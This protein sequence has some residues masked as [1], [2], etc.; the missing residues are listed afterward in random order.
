MVE[1]VE[2]LGPETKSHGLG[3]AKV[4][5][6]PD[7][8]L[9]SAETAQ[10]IAPETTL[11]PDGRCSKSRAIEDLAARISRPIELQWHSWINVRAGIEGDA[12]GT[13]NGAHEAN[14]RSRSGQ[15]E[16]VQRPAAPESVDHLMR[17]WRGQIVGHTGGESMPD[18]K[19][20]MPTVCIRAKSEAGV[21]RNVANASVEALSIEWDKV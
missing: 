2:E 16:P 17:P 13:E 5:L 6:H 21:L 7:I 20:R 11:L 9:G 10:H 14:G 19:I 18:V 8:R 4:P 1:D 15:N 12:G 3:D